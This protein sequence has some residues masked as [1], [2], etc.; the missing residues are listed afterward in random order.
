L[1]KV[2]SGEGTAAKLVN[3]G[4]LYEELLETTCRLKALLE[5]MKSFVAQS[6]DKGVPIKLK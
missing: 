3:D 2:D 1:E 5:D 4:R 6:K